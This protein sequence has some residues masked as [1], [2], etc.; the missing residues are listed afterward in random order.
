MPEACCSEGEDQTLVLGGGGGGPGVRTT[1]KV[2]AKR[3]RS[4]AGVVGGSLVV[5]VLTTPFPEDLNKNCR[6][7][8]QVPRKGDPYTCAF[9]VYDGVV[10]HSDRCV[11]VF[12]PCQEPKDRSGVFW[13][14]GPLQTL[15]INEPTYN[16]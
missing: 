3:S 11:V 16:W 1:R 2:R 8:L 15:L 6:F 13:T 12:V 4:V 7:P 5:G 10:N 9:S 14:V